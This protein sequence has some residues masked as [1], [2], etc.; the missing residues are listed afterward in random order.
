MNQ[1]KID[2]GFGNPLFMSYPL[3]GVV[4]IGYSIPLAYDTLIKEIKDV[5]IRFNNAYID[6]RYIVIGNG[7]S[8]ILQGLTHIFNRPIIADA[9]YYLRFPELCNLN[10]I[11]WGDDLKIYTIPN[12]PDNSVP[13]N[14]HSTTDAIFDFCYN[15][16]QY[17]N[18]VKLDVDIAVYSLSKLTGNAE[19]RI[20]WAILKNKDLAI[21]LKNYI[22]LATMGVSRSSMFDA[23]QALNYLDKGI[24]YNLY[25]SILD[26]RWTQISS[27]KLPFKVLNSSGMF[28]WCEG[29]CP[30]EIECILGNKFGVSNNYFRLNLGCSEDQFK[31]FINIWSC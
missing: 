6:D 14:I 15:W 26:N 19:L 27:L 29:E 23:A 10:R 18:P 9:P 11:P 24:I 30:K 8:Q 2:L 21:K 22:E 28:M 12:N 5:H 4:P 25:K 17:H 3:G 16:P 1:K 31:Q 20:G 13:K 7:A